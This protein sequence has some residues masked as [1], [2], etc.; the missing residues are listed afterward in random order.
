[1]QDGVALRHALGQTFDPRL[2]DVG[3]RGEGEYIY[4][5]TFLI[6]GHEMVTALD[7]KGVEVTYL[8]DRLFAR[9]VGFG[10]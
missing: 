3:M 1:M 2:G 4:V 7:V 9:G 10:V 6:V 8:Y 5:H